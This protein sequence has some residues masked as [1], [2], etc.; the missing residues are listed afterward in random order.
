MKWHFILWRFV[1]K[2]HYIYIY[3]TNQQIH[4][5]KIYLLYIN[6]HQ[7]ALVSS[8]TNARASHKNTDNIQTVAQKSN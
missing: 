4:T 5:Y 3:A 6:M 8:I 7:H 1:F 2:C